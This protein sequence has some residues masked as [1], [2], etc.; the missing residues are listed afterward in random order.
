[1]IVKINITH[2]IIYKLD[3]DTVVGNGEVVIVNK[4]FDDCDDSGREMIDDNNTADDVDPD[5]VDSTLEVT[6]VGSTINSPCD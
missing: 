3:G 1:M 2:I 5:T 4:I 6:D